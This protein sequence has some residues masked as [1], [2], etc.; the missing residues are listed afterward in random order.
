MMIIIEKRIQINNKG[1]KTLGTEDRL[2][3]PNKFT[4]I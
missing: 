3:I 2:L 1:N 4:V